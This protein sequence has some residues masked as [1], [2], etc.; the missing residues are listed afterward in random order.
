MLALSSD[1][2]LGYE[3]RQSTQSFRT[4]GSR[5][6]RIKRGD[7]YVRIHFPERQK[8]S[9]LL[10]QIL[11]QPD[12]KIF[13]SFFSSMSNTGVPGG[14]WFYVPNQ[15][16]AILFAVMFALI[17]FAVSYH[18]FRSGIHRFSAVV[19]LGILMEIGGFSCRAVAR[20]KL[21]QT[22]SSSILRI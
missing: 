15:A 2:A 14:V 4:G 10:R 19:M 7:A 13:I 3:Q 6:H 17:G 21:D 9:T 5:V 18:S 11:L 22:V 8:P 1:G 12:R 16:A 20:H